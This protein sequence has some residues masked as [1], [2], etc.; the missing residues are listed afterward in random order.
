METAGKISQRPAG[1]PLKAEAESGFHAALQPP[2]GMQG[3]PGTK[4]V[5]G[6]GRTERS[7]DGG[8]RAAPGSQL[9]VSSVIS[10]V[11]LSD[12]HSQL[13]PPPGLLAAGCT[14][15]AEGTPNI[16]RRTG[17]AVDAP[18]AG[19]PAEKGQSQTPARTTRL[20]VPCRR[21]PPTPRGQHTNGLSR[22]TLFP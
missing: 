7:Q 11:D 17:L 4:A 8:T 20:P 6:K 1:Q 13:D 15:E 21:V 18:W 5:P 19:S 9:A 16:R 10:S 12:A 3:R 22:G 14:L 2:W